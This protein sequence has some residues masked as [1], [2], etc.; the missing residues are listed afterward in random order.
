[1]S[2]VEERK[3]IYAETR[4][5]LLKRQLSNAENYD[6]SILSLATAA[7]GFSLA[8]LKEIVPISIAKDFYLIKISWFFLILT[9]LVTLISFLSSQIAINKQFF[10]AKEYY[11]N[12]NDDFLNKKNWPAILTEGLNWASAI[13]FVIAIVITTIFVSINTTNELSL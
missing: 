4:A 3:K 9:I 8:F 10:Y 11:L 6:K 1:M 2:D 5:D 7:L 12:S 13:F